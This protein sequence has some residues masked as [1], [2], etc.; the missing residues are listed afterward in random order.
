MAVAAEHQAETAL[1]Q[2]LRWLSAAPLGALAQLGCRLGYL[3]R[4]FVYLSIGAIALLAA[5]DAIP[6]AEGA[7]GSMEA[8]AAW[9]AGFVLLWTTGLG[10]Y[11]FAGWR[12]LQAVF[13]ADRQGVSIKA[14]LSRIGQG[15]SAVVYGVLAWSVFGALDTL[16]DLK[17]PE[18]RGAEQAAVSQALSMPGGAWLVLGAGLFILAAGAANLVKAARG[19]LEDRLVCAR[20]VRR[21][22]GAVGRF[23]YGARGAAFVVVGVMMSRAGLHASVAE[24]GGLEDAL[25]ALERAPFGDPIMTATAVG[26]IAFGA[27]AVIEARYRT[28]P[29]GDVVE[30]D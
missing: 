15:I 3:A 7:L 16:E 8:W 14:V 12:V 17:D 27:F 29:A 28:L 11:G 13:D 24:A 18:D 6:R 22:A 19:G 21:V 26:L 5:I 20:G 4:G 10:L 23:G 2:T 9:P 25:Q 30:G 1:R